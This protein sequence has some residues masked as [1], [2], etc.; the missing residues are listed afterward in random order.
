MKNLNLRGWIKNKSVWLILLLLIVLYFSFGAYHL[1]QF[2]TADEHFWFYNRIPQYWKSI[3]SH[4]WE[5]TRIND[6]P[7]ISVAMISGA[8]LFFQKN[9]EKLEIKDLIQP[10]PNRTATSLDLNRTFRLPI[11][12]FNGLFSLYLFY[13]LNKLFK[14]KW[15]SLLSVSAIILSPTLL[16]I[17]Q[18]VNPD[19]LMWSFSAAA[20]FSFAALLYTG[21]KKFWLFAPLFL[22]MSL[23]SK[24]SAAVL[25]PFFFTV[26]LLY[27]FIEKKADGDI[28][29]QRLKFGLLGYLATVIGSLVFFSLFMPA[30]FIKI[31]YLTSGTIDYPGMKNILIPIGIIWLL[32]L[33]DSIFNYGKIVNWIYK[34]I[35]PTKEYFFSAFFG[36]LSFIII[37]MLINAV[38][39]LDFLK[40]HSIP[41]DIR[42][43]K[44]F[45]KGTTFIQK[46]F[47][48]FRQL[49]FS[50]QPFVLAGILWLWIRAAISKIPYRFIILI[51]SA[52]IIVYYLAVI[53]Q[54]LLAN[55]RYSIMLYP[56]AITLGA[57]GI[58]D[59][60]AVMKKKI[61]P[62]WIAIG[63]ISVS[64]FSLW[65]AKP[66]Y[67]NYTNA[68][69]PQKYIITGAWG[70]GGYE[71]AQYINSQPNPENLRVWTDYQGTCEFIKGMCMTKNYKFDQSKYAFDYFVFSRRGQILDTKKKG[72][73][74]PI[75]NQPV[76]SLEIGGRP[77]NYVKVYKSA[78]NPQ[79]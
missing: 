36:I 46:I 42:Q 34:K 57:V 16:G 44:D 56:I 51:S 20:I 29:N 15:L 3:A 14:N 65:E 17:S 55:I 19:S 31:N 18:I 61:A 33:I 25:Y 12:I 9:P 52:F 73:E 10:D 32:M 26:L 45:I 71:A 79:K 37:I 72:N 50:L 30:V 39:G 1:A 41:F 38:S 49:V 8:G 70:Y 27:F 74:K 68:L 22:A 43:G 24:Y 64:T 77:E 63:L 5:K 4:K 53:T 62:A 6:K 23:L 2:T 35:E 28:D 40:I 7:G 66:F 59:F 67:F 21:E 54:D 11:L 78:G 69:L 47:L 60:F 48:E 13:V 58:W 75:G 76:W